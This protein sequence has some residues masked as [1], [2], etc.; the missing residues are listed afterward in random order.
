[1]TAG[2]RTT[3]I[4]LWSIAG[5]VVLSLLA[6]EC[7]FA[8]VPRLAVARR[9]SI[10]LMQRIYRRVGVPVCGVWERE[11]AKAAHG[12][13]VSPFDAAICGNCETY[14]CPI[15]EF[16][17]HGNVKAPYML[18]YAVQKR[19]STRWERIRLTSVDMSAPFIFSSRHADEERIMGTATICLS[20]GEITSILLPATASTVAGT[21]PECIEIRLPEND[22]KCPPGKCIAAIR[23]QPLL[24]EH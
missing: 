19:G 15:A 5:L 2:W 16:L 1:M 14:F 7:W 21:V 3:R 17:S 10:E 4:S 22:E 18:V 20:D 11:Q 13:N 6:P 8:P 24:V 9:H 12:Q 23:A